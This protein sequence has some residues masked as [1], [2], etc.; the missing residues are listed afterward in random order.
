[1]T[2]YCVVCGGLIPTTRQGGV[3]CSKR[4]AGRLGGRP[5]GPRRRKVA[6]LNKQGYLYLTRSM[7]TP[8]EAAL[9]HGNQRTI[10]LHRLVAARYLGRPL[11]PE[12]Y[13]RHMNG[14]KTDN[15]ISNLEIGS[16]LDNKIDHASAIREMEKWRSIAVLVL[17]ALN[18][19]R[20][21]ERRE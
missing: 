2:R 11:S 19:Q 10:L 13:V 18:K 16:A 21:L 9:F 1:M 12:E 4:C 8:D 15:R 14:V 7:L 17:M 3:V 20:S 6:K 5:K